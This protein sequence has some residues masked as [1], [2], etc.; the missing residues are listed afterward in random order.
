MPSHLP[1][2]ARQTVLAPLD[3]RG[4]VA[5]VERRLA[6]AIRVGVFG[7]GDQLPSEAELAAQLGVATVTLR[8]ALVGLRRTGLVETRRGRNGGTFV[9][10][11]ADA[12]HARLLERLDEL[13]VDDLRDLADHRTAIAGAAA[14]LA[15]ERASGSDLERLEQHVER[16]ARAGT[17]A[18]RRAADA[19]FHVELAATTR[20]LRLTRA[21]MDLQTEAGAL[22]WLAGGGA[23]AEWALRDHRAVLA[24]VTARDADAARERIVAHVEAE[25]TAVVALHLAGNAAAST[26]RHGG[27]PT[28]AGATGDRTPRRSGVRRLRG[29]AAEVLDLVQETLG[30]VFLDVADVRVAVLGLPPAPSRADLGPVRELVHTTLARQPLLAGTGMVFAPGSLADA[31]RWLEWWRSTLP[32][33]PVFLDA[34]LDPADPDFYD[35]EQAEWF[36]TPRD[37]GERWIAG[38]FLDHSGTN[39]HIL[40]LT[41]PV[42]RDGAFL[43]VAGADIAVGGIEAIG[44]TALAALD[45]EAALVNHR[46]RIIATNTP[47]RLVGTLWPG[48]DGA[49]PPRGDD[50]VVRDP[51]LLWSVVVAR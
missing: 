23:G 32:G 18:E 46:G 12:A 34:S 22:V 24:A 41:L 49:W 15:A 11:P 25:M 31:P 26:S 1:L 13:S 50:L 36:T 38:P 21:E 39:E 4:R 37:T 3:R 45:G 42:V 5:E 29:Q 16:L 27:R 20:S 6:E 7:D 35:Y 14:A 43:G 10:A 47:R 44:G 48:A 2:S 40:T 30:D 17:D 9:H 51:R 28:H 8:E 19:R 33:A